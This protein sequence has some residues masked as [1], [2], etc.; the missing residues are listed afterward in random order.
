MKILY[1]VHQFYP[2]HHT[3]TEKFLLNL[4]TTMQKWG[5]RVKVLA[6]SFYDDSFYS[7]GE[8]NLLT[9]EFSYKGIEVFAF[10][11]RA[12]P[13]GFGYALEDPNI[14]PF[15]ESF[16]RKENPDI[17]HVAHPMRMGE[18][19]H[20]AIRLHIP[21]VIT[22]TDFW[23]MCPKA[24]LYTSKNTLCMGPEKG[25]ACKNYCPEY[26]H[27]SISHRLKLSEQIFHNASSVIAPSRF[28]ARLFKTEFQ[29]LEPKFI[30]YGIDFAYIKRNN[31]LYDGTG[32][33]VVMYAGQIEYHKGVHI[34]IDAFKHLKGENLRLKLYGSGPEKTVRIFQEMAKDDRRIEFCG[35]YE[36]NQIGE[37]FG[38]VDIAVIPSNWHENNTITMREALACHVPCV[39]SSAGGMMEKIQN[40][41]NG[42]VFRM[43]DAVHLREVLE[44]VIT[45]PELF[46]RM[47]K[48]LRS[49]SL[50]TAEQEAYAYERVY[51]EQLRDG[52]GKNI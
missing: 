12:Y 5:N 48:N 24:I 35:V 15:A 25:M 38:K 47:K 31:R 10:K 52:S 37:I 44:E 29:F 30:P 13:P 43:G 41:V 17:I 4:S 49:Y 32:D 16:L 28:L 34:L 21:Y 18:F 14:R 27:D 7:S 3:G 39:V 50:T 1:V 11:Y 45:R 19:I 9:K 33:F 42:F 20:A 8:S 26:D 23:L 22:M 40:G 6:Y 51:Q 46:Q 36:E 2:M